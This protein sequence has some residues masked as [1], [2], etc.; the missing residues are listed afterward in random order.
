MEESPMES[1]SVLSNL[2][3]GTQHLVKN[4]IVALIIYI[5]GKKLIAFNNPD[6]FVRISEKLKAFVPQQVIP[7]AEDEEYELAEEAYFYR[8]LLKQQPDGHG[9]DVAGYADH[10]NH[11][12]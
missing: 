3:A 4:I 9:H 10:H 1:L 6:C 2:A 11:Q 12:Q 5:V 7:P 8:S